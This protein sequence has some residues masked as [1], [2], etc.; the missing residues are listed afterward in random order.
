MTVFESTLKLFDWFSSNDSFVLE[1]DFLKLILISNNEERDKAS[2]LLALD[3]LKEAGM[4]KQTLIQ[5]NKVWVLERSLQNLSQK[6]EIDH[7]LALEM[8]KVLNDAAEKYNV[9]NSACDPQ[10][11]TNDNLKDLIVLAGVTTKVDELDE[12]D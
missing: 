7:S 4:I 10:N 6:I 8:A 12:E 3:S 11:L 5:E 2:V 1:E 9:K